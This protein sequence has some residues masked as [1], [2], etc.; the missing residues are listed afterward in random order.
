MTRL[1][2]WPKILSI[3]L[4]VIATLL[5]IAAIVVPYVFKL[6]ENDATFVEYRETPIGIFIITEE[7][8]DKLIITE[9]ETVNYEVL[10]ILERG[11]IIHFKTFDLYKQ[12]EETSIIVLQELTYNNKEILH[13][14]TDEK[15]YQDQK[16]DIII[17]IVLLILSGLCFYVYKKNNK[18]PKKK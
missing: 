9:K 13:N 18:F 11:D 7:Y 2:K 16:Q 8:D 15:M 6:T 3:I 5:M 4:F 1:V 17:A 10:S 12:S 14:N